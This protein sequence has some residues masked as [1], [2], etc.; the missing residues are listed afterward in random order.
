M[1]GI[2]GKI[3]FDNNSVSEQ[4]ILAMNEKIM[5]RGPDDGGV[6]ISPDRKVGLGHRR[7]SIIDLSPL[8]HQPMNYQWRDL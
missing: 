6:Y 2:T 3:Y 7:L 8:G 5:H 4:D 1:C